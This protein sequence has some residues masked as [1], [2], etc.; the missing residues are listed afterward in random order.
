MVFTQLKSVSDDLNKY[1]YLAKENS[2][3][4]VTE[5]ENGE[6]YN[7]TIDDNTFGLTRGEI[8]AINHLTGALEYENFSCS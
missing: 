7:I 5:W 1:D 3:I 2:F 8:S 4:Q 6:G